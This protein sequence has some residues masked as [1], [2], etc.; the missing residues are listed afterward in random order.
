MNEQFRERTW[1]EQGQLVMPFY[2]VCDVSYSMANDMRCSTRAFGGFAGLSCPS[3]SWT[4]SRRSASFLL[5]WRKGSP[6]DDADERAGIPSSGWRAARTRRRLPHTGPDD[7][8]GH[9]EPQGAMDT[10]STGRAR[11]F[12]PTVSPSTRT[13]I[14]PSP[15]RSPMTGPDRGRDEGAPDLRPLRLP[16]RARG[17]AR[18]LAYP[19]DRAKWY[20]SKS[21]DSRR[22][23]KGILDII[24]NT[25]ITSGSSASAGSRL[26]PSKRQP[27]AA[28]SSMATRTMDCD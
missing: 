14:R 26:S 6:A 22:P 2:L 1:A 28:G 11:S 21:H 17:R 27:R 3:L 15:A 5:R 4:T 18:K 8:P 10:R 12:S 16:E 24:M 23:S 7:R 9:G 20:H 25:V 13:G 19:L